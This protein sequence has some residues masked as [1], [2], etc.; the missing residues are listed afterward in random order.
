VVTK[1]ISSRLDCDKATINRIF[2]ALKATLDNGIPSRKKGS[3]RPM[4]ITGVLA[5]LKMQLKKFPCMKAGQL[6]Q[7][8]P[9]LASLTDCRVQYALQKHLNMPSRVAALKSLS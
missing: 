3:G 9:K 1:N 6:R 5:A 7:T 4:K 8:V 2:S